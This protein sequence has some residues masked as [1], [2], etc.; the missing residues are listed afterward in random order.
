M[1]Q[2]TEPSVKAQSRQAADLLSIDETAFVVGE[3]LDQAKNTIAE[4]ERTVLSAEDRI[5]LLAAL[6]HH[7][8]PTEA[9]RQ[10]M[11]LHRTALVHGG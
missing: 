6:D 8:D 2:R 10:A 5:A 11:A 3:T 4:P 9:L 1:E 7:A